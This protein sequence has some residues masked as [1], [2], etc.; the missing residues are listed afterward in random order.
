MQRRSRAQ[1]D[2][3]STA[4][5]IGQDRRATYRC[6][7]V[8]F[9][10]RHLVSRQELDFTESGVRV[11]QLN[12]LTQK[13]HDVTHLFTSLNVTRTRIHTSPHW[14]WPVLS[15]LFA[16]GFALNAHDYSVGDFIVAGMLTTAPFLYWFLR[17]VAWV[18]Y[19]PLF[20]WDLGVRSK[21]VL[22]EVQRCRWAYVV[23]HVARADVDQ[24]VDLVARA[25]KDELI[26][27]ELAAQLHS[28]L[29]AGRYHPGG[30][31]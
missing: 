22:D 1:I 28:Q 2:A 8:R 13:T 24:A 25:R 9:V 21:T 12:R 10:Q 3:S 6:R 27:R 17:R 29:D 5:L 26:S 15:V 23:D 7:R 19:A 30:Y 16:I 14:F 31:L 18:G 11:V 20:I 4:V